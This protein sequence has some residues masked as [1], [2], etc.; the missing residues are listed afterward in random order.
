MCSLGPSLSVLFTAAAHRFGRLNDLV[1]LGRSCGRMLMLHQIIFPNAF[2]TFP[3]VP[4]WPALGNCNLWLICLTAGVLLVSSRSTCVF[5][6]FLTVCIINHHHFAVLFLF[7]QGPSR[8]LSFSGCSAT[9]LECPAFVRWIG[10]F[11]GTI[12]RLT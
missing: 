3:I 12:T 6:F 7:L 10:F 1:P 8:N 2:H 9:Y 5:F 4:V 11:A